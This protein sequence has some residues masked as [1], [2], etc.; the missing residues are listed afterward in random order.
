[1][2]GVLSAILVGLPKTFVERDADGRSKSRRTGIYKMP[3]PEPVAVRRLGIVGDGQA[4]LKY[5]GGID[6]P[7]LAYC[8]EHY[9]RWR[10][11][12]RIAEMVPGGFGENFLLRS[13]TTPM[14]ETTVCI[15]DRFEIGE[16][17]VEVSQPRQPCA[18]LT[19]R[20]N[21]PQLAQ[22]ILDH[23]RG[24]WYMRVLREGAV[25]SGD[26]II[27]TDHPFPQ[28]TIAKAMQIMYQR[29]LPARATLAECPALSTRWVSQLQSA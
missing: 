24:G 29:D 13:D 11:Q 16:I 17:E 26:R 10:E 18:T 14:D 28:W 7:I 22:L 2:T 6:A 4:N 5:H 8:G 20:W 3:A 27:R 1:M 21:M 25:R 15:G 12:L 23:N 19:R 9:P